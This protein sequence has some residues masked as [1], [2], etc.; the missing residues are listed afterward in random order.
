MSLQHERE[1][2][3]V[4][5]TVTVDLLLSLLMLPLPQIKEIVWYLPFH[6]AV[7]VANL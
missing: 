6:T 3:Y 5:M 4:V 7:Y 2:Y 1:Y